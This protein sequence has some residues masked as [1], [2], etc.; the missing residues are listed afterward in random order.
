MSALPT[1]RDP[2]RLADDVA[3]CVH[4][5]SEP[6]ARRRSVL[7]LSSFFGTDRMLLHSGF[8]P[9]LGSDVDLSVWSPLIDEPLFANDHPYR[10]HFRQAMPGLS[11]P[12]WLNLLRRISD[13][14]AFL[15]HHYLPRWRFLLWPI[16][17][18]AMSGRDRLRPPGG[19]SDV[20]SAEM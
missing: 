7:C 11:M 6:E 20:A 12:H 5:T 16:V 10:Q 9:T 13:H 4:R 1:V 15:R 8:V 14:H 17:H 19:R 2:E 3:R 18:W